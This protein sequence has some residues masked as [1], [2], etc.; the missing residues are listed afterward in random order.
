MTRRSRVVLVT[1]AAVVAV[2]LLFLRFVNDTPGLESQERQAAALERVV[3]HRLKAGRAESH[4]RNWLVAH[5]AGSKIVAGTVVSEG[6]PVADA[7]VKLVNVLTNTGNATQPLVQ[8]GADGTF[9]FGEQ[10]PAAV[11]LAVAAPGYEPATRRLRLDLP[12]GTFD[13]LLVELQRCSRPLRGRILDVDGTPLA[14]AG[15]SQQHIVAPEHGGFVSAAATIADDDGRFELCISGDSRSLLVASAPGYAAREVSGRFGRDTIEIRLVPEA[16]LMGRVVDEAGDGVGGAVVTLARPV[17]S[18]GISGGG[19]LPMQSTV[20]DSDG[21]FFMG[22]IHPGRYVLHADHGQMFL[23]HEPETIVLQAGETLERTIAMTGGIRVGGVVVEGEQPIAGQS[24]VIDH[25][26][27]AFTDI[28]GVF[29]THCRASE[30]RREVIVSRHSVE[31]P[32]TVQ[33]PRATDRLVIDVRARGAVVGRVT[34][35]GSPA[36]GA[37]VAAG[38]RHLRGEGAAFLN[39]RADAE[40]RFVLSGLPPGTHDVV[41]QAADGSMSV[42]LPTTVADG[43]TVDVGDLD[44]SRLGRLTGTVVDRYGAPVAQARIELLGEAHSAR[45]QADLAGRFEVPGLQLGSY[46]VAL[47]SSAGSKLTIASGATTVALSEAAPEARVSL[48]VEPATGT[49]RGVVRY[50]DGT[51]PTE[52]RVRAL[53]T[54]GATAWVNATLDGS[55]ELTGLHGTQYDL[56][57]RASSGERAHARAVVPNER[58]VEIT[59]SRAGHIEGVVVGADNATVEARYEGG[60]A[61][62]LLDQILSERTGRVV[63]REGRFKIS[64][65]APGTYTVF[66][67]ATGKS[68]QEQVVVRPGEVSQVRLELDDARRLTGR[69]VIWPEASPA[70]GATC[71]YKGRVARTTE[72]GAFSFGVAGREPGVVR[73]TGSGGR[74]GTAVIGD[75]VAEV[76]VPL[77]EAPTGIGARLRASNGALVVVGADPRGVLLEGDQLERVDGV[78]VKLNLLDVLAHLSL[79]PPGETVRLEVLRAGNTQTVDV[80]AVPAEAP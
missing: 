9:T 37:V 54:G 25:C 66:A 21:A 53:S 57:V 40:G 72:R 63:T 73:C 59:L 24:V 78:S 45:S 62:D 67:A 26:R 43:Q 75:P 6:G 14:G 58:L 11:L 50:D 76:I 48:V 64:G 55:F 20:S 49:I 17:T 2:G 44:I 15:L 52:A 31:S 13:E 69:V 7:T 56:E 19:G 41:A 46:S 30:E 18:E 60:G 38:T 23:Q 68:A 27:R 42:P 79:R 61:A 10:P 70:P 80:E 12:L 32:K 1:V 22:G 8:T 35:G 36:A 4:R 47:E 3:Q 16:A 65:I 39:A 51:G 28:A 71:R 34:A 5:R 74:A 77:V 33:L 29:E